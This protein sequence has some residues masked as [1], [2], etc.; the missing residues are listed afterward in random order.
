MA[1]TERRQQM[2]ISCKKGQKQARGTHS[3]IC[4]R[5]QSELMYQCGQEGQGP[6]PRQHV[7]LFSGVRAQPQAYV[8]AHRLYASSGGQRSAGRDSALEHESLTTAEC[9]PA[10]LGC[11]GSC[12]QTHC[13][14]Q[15]TRTTVA[16]AP[17]PS[18]NPGRA[19]GGTLPQA[20]H[21]VS[22]VHAARQQARR[23]QPGGSHPR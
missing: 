5:A 13:S 12:L 2:M 23:L 18:T 6:Q 8:A 3:H 15:H 22:A 7:K 4:Y 11:L 17:L 10:F 19:C 9:P 1:A 14:H 21:C 20:Q 16:R